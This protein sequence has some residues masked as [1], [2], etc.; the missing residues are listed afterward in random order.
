MLRPNSLDEALHHLSQ[1]DTAVLAGGTYIVARGRHRGKRLLDLNALELAHLT[2]DGESVRCGAMVR[3]QD[4]ID[5]TMLGSFGAV[6]ADAARATSASW[7]LRNMSSIGG[8]LVER[9]CYSAIPLAMLALDAKIELAT[10][11]GMHSLSLDEFY[12]SN[13]AEMKPF[14]LVEVTI[15]KPRPRSRLAL[16]RL[17]QLPSQ[18]SI[19]ATAINLLV[20]GQ[21]V[22]QARVA[23]GGAATVPQRLYAF[24]NALASQRREVDTDLLRDLCESGL[25]HVEFPQ[26]D[27]STTGYAREASKVLL[28]RTCTELLRLQD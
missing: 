27:D 5:S 17:A 21:I 9:N 6:L 11:D 15:S 25:D 18:Q 2:H 26:T 22:R 4:F 14:I 24:E 8:E 1:G 13:A 23:L 19:A 7:M 20:D 3:I 28:R 16:H 10:L 12:R